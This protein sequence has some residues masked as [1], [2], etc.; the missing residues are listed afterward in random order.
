[1]EDIKITEDRHGRYVKVVHELSDGEEVV[2]NVSI[3]NMLLFCLQEVTKDIV[4][5][6]MR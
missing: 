1:M 4:K 5:E 6:A 3:K 2:L